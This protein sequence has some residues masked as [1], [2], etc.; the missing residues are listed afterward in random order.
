MSKVLGP[1]WTGLGAPAQ[2][3]H[4]SVR[5][6]LQGGSEQKTQ[7]GLAGTCPD[8]RLKYPSMGPP[9]QLGPL[10]VHWMV[11]EALQCGKGSAGA[12]SRPSQ[13]VLLDTGGALSSLLG[14]SVPIWEEDGSFPRELGGLAATRWGGDRA[15]ICLPPPEEAPAGLRPVSITLPGFGETSLSAWTASQVT[16][17]RC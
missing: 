9:Q 11:L 8:R 10:S 4:T 2:H 5:R 14:L 13:A 15:A 16:C 7:L 12:V 3:G 17:S 1:A 6:P